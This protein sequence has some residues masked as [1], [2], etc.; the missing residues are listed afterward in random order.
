MSPR[1]LL[2][3][4]FALCI[5][6]QDLLA[7][8]FFVPGASSIRLFF[9]PAPYGSFPLHLEIIVVMTLHGGGAA[10]QF[11]YLLIMF[12]FHPT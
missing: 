2:R 12:A 6:Y 5:F 4:L 9:L 11:I 1:R 10:E 8:T 7:L 3:S